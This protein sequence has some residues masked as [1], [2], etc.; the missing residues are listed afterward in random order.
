[1]GWRM[2]PFFNILELLADE[3]FGV[4]GENADDGGLEL[5]AD[6]GRRFGVTVCHWL[7]DMGGLGSGICVREN[8]LP[9]NAT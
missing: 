9:T 2:H 6:D 5:A 4:P 7:D 3:D 8:N 1:M